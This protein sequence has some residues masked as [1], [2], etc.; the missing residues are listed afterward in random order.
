MG[1]NQQQ[2][3][4]QQQ[5]QQPENQTNQVS[6]DPLKDQFAP[7]APLELTE[8]V[9]AAIQTGLLDAN[10]PENFSEAALKQPMVYVENFGRLVYDNVI[11]EKN[12]ERDRVLGGAQR[13]HSTGEVQQ[14]LKHIVDMARASGYSV[15][16]A[17]IVPGE[18]PQISVVPSIAGG[19]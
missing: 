6:D 4:R 5:A 11:G 9:Q 19:Q 18:A 2:Q 10:D 14:R 13:F 12:A 8:A 7:D 17:N 15:T 1:K 3:Q 16:I